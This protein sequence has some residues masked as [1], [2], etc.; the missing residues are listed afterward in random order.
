MT[1]K[2]SNILGR[3]LFQTGQFRF[4]LASI[5]DLSNDTYDT[6]Q[7]QRDINEQ[8]VKELTESFMESINETTYIKYGSSIPHIILTNDGKK[9]IIDGQHRVK[10]YKKVCEMHQNAYEI[11]VLYEQCLNETQIKES[12]KRSNTQW[13]QSDTMIE[14]MYNEE[15]QQQKTNGTKQQEFIQ[16]LWNEKLKDYNGTKGMVSRSTKPKKPNINENNFLEMLQ[17]LEK[18]GITFSS[19][20]KL[21]DAYERAN[22]NI[23]QSNFEKYSK[24]EKLWSKC[25]KFN[26][27]VGL[28]SESEFLKIMER[29]NEKRKPVPSGLKKECWRTKFSN[30]SNGKCE[31]CLKVIEAL[32]FEAGHIISCYNGGEDTKENLV[33]ICKDCNR[34]MGT[35]N[36]YEYKKEHYPT[37]N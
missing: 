6:W 32:D 1:T 24:N 28:V 27:F 10:A 4:C 31:V 21:K 7:G 33:P 5:Q 18:N 19:Y 15:E 36:L 30:N 37:K 11:I 20:V 26:C 14:N 2:F 12:F 22:E 3:I 16:K 23:R 17:N 13:I 8:H 9:Y 34:S 35:Q 25:V 29:L